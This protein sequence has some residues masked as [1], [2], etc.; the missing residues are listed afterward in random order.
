MSVKIYAIRVIDD[1]AVYGGLG[2]PVRDDGWALLL[3]LDEEKRKVTGITDD[4]A[5]VKMLTS[6]ELAHDDEPMGDLPDE[7]GRFTWTDGHLIH[8]D[9][10]WECQ[11]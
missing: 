9:G 4:V 11:P 7:G 8:R 10:A 3:C 1:R 6:V 5:Y 2:L